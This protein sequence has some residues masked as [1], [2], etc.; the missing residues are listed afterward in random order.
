MS[1]P[2]GA[3]EVVTPCDLARSSIE[4]AMET[5]GTHIQASNGPMDHVYYFVRVHLGSVLYAAQELQPY[6]MALIIDPG[7]RDVDEWSLVA[8]GFIAGPPARHVKAE[9]WSP[10]A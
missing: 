4:Y 10:G 8:H 3:L 6:G 2:D 9:I 1:K 7:Y 5:L